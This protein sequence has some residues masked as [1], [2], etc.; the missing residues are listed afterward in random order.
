MRPHLSTQ[1]DYKDDVVRAGVIATAFWGMAGLAVGVLIAFQL[2][3]PALN[4]DWGAP[5]FEYLRDAFDVLY[6]EG[7]E[8]PRMMQVALHNRLVGRPGRAAHPC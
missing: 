1:G 2:A 4:F 5:F 7:S 6:E 3:F 8:C